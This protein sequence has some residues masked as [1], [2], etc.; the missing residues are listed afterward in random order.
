M[1]RPLQVDLVEGEAASL[2]VQH[3]VLQAPWQVRAA[4]IGDL[5]R[6]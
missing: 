3:L 6:M 5:V 2:D 1:Q 4:T